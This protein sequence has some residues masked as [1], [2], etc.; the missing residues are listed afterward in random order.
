MIKDPEM[1]GLVSDNLK[2]KKI[3]KHAVK[4]LPSL[5]KYVLSHIRLKEYVITLF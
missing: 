2:T 4:K 5:I 3:C 1:L